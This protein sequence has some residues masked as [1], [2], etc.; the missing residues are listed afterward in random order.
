MKQVFQCDW[1]GERGTEEV[2]REHEAN[3][4]FNKS[5]RACHTCGYRKG[6]GFNGFQCQNGKNIPEGKYMKHCKDW[7][8]DGSTFD[9]KNPYSSIFDCFFG[10]LPKSKE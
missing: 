4:S 5:L 3:C 10:K 8:E 6:F 2:I 7:V 1:C 9:T